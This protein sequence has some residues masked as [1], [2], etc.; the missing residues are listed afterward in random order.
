MRD[1]LPTHVSIKT[2]DFAKFTK[3]RSKVHAQSGV[4]KNPR[5]ELILTGIYANNSKLKYG[6]G[7]IR[8]L[9]RVAP[10]SVFKTDA[11]KE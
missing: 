4:Q 5:R 1:F 2:K 7:G 6:K 9:G 10:T 11:M 8:T 3:T